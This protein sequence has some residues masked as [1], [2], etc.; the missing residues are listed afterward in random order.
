MTGPSDAASSA[1]TTADRNSDHKA[2]SMRKELE[3]RLVRRWPSWFDIHGDVR[4]TL[5][6][7]GFM[8][9]DG[10]FALLW[11]LCERLEPLVAEFER[12]TGERFEVIE[13]KQKF[14][15][16]RFY[17]SHS[18][19]LVPAAEAIRKCIEDAKAESVR[20]CEVCGQP[21]R[22]RRLRGWFFAACDEHRDAPV[23]E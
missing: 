5:M 10:W 14:G 4:L 15:G 2:G 23:K 16:L 6:S 8:C 21:G 13:V 17:T 7:F 9:G 11:R 20:A 3:E 1:R 19:G 18:F 22:Q 12:K